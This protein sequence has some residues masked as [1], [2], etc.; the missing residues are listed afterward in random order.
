VPELP[1]RPEMN[2]KRLAAREIE[3]RAAAALR[4]F[5]LKLI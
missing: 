5:L 1:G 2:H 3:L 4:F